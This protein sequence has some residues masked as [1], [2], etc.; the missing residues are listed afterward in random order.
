MLLV[1]SL[2]PT[3]LDVPRITGRFEEPLVS[4]ALAEVGIASPAALLAT[5]VMGREGLERYT[6]NSPAVTDDHPRIEYATWVRRGEIMRVLPEILALRTNLP[7]G[8]TNDSFRAQVEE[9]RK[10][11][12]GFY[13][14][15]LDAYK[16]DRE[17]WARNLGTVMKADP[18]NPYYLWIE[19]GAANA[20]R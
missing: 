16:G 4:A 14:A 6:G 9:E 19:G 18:G 2:Q 10:N 7:L 17:A 11:L 1:G 13:E 12:L 20:G 15:A 3:E 5:W 8:G